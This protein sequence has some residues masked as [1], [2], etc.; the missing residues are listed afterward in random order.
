MLC[1]ALS[2]C[3]VLYGDALHCNQELAC[4]ALANLAYEPAA[5]PSDECPPEASSI[6]AVGKS[7]VDRLLVGIHQG[8]FLSSRVVRRFKPHGKNKREPLQRVAAAV[9]ADR[10]RYHAVNKRVCCWKKRKNDRRVC[11]FAGLVNREFICFPEC[12]PFRPPFFFLKY[13]ILRRRDNGRS[14][15]Y[16]YP[17]LPRTARSSVQCSVEDLRAINCI[18]QARGGGHS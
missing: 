16:Q 3:T 6:Y 11:P 13:P 7:V 10:R 4:D 17:H 2:C 9:E 8:L 18:K 15:Q 5:S 12:F 1:C 14:A